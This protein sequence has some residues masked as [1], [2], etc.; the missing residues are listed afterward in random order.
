VRELLTI[1]NKGIVMYT[2]KSFSLKQDE[3][4]R[5]WWVI[6]ATDLVVG[7]LATE[8]ATLLRGKHK[9]TFTPN[10]ECGD[11]VVI[12]NCDKVKFTGK[13][14]DDKDYFWHTNYIGGIKKRT[15]KEQLAKHPEKIIMEA[16]KGML[17]KNTLGRKQLTKLKVFT[18]TEHAHEAQKPE[19]Y[20]IK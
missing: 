18:G 10:Q 13:K 6:D 15:A 19:T 12:T 11:F 17:P 5:K 20:T 7:R 14:W 1:F 3:I 16:V 9:P 8:V 4:D 2:Q